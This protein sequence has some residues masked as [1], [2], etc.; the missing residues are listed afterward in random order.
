MEEE[1]EKEE[2]YFSKQKHSVQPFFCLNTYI[3]IKKHYKIEEHV[4]TNA[5]YK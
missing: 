5:G 1:E 2:I 3:S 4:L